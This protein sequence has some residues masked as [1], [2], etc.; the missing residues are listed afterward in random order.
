MVEKDSVN[1]LNS[2]K[3]TMCPYLNK[4]IWQNVEVVVADG[5]ENAVDAFGFAV[6]GELTE[7]DDATKIKGI[8]RLDP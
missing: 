4:D 6:D 5:H 2:M 3:V 1:S 8:L 7:D